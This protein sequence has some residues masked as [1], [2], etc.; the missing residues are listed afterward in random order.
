MG[1]IIHISVVTV[2]VRSGIPFSSSKDS[3][4]A[5]DAIILLNNT[6]L[7]G[8]FL[9]DD[10]KSVVS[11][12][13]SGAISAVVDQ[14]IWP[15]RVVQPSYAETFQPLHLFAPLDYNRV[16]LTSLLGHISGLESDGSARAYWEE[17]ADASVRPD[18]VKRCNIDVYDVINHRSI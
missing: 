1:S 8:N 12:E 17:T 15:R 3:K 9:S 6:C 18:D 13:N 10:A 7:L 2:L 4:R 16:A 11:R 14:Q 5:L